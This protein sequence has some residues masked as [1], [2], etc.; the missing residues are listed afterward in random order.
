MKEIIDK[1]GSHEEDL[2]LILLC[3]IDKTKVGNPFNIVYI[4]G[5][6]TTIDFIIKLHEKKIKQQKI[7]MIRSFVLEFLPVK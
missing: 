5:V 4:E 6:L 2:E 7:F 1:I 3:L